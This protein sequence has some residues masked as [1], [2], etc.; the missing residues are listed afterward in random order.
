[1][2]AFTRLR[3]SNFSATEQRIADYILRNSANL[4]NLTIS[5]VAEACGTSKSMVVQLCK[6]AGFKG[7]KDLCSQLLIEHALSDQR[8]ESLYE[9]VHPGFSVA[10]ICQITV[11]Q[12]IRSIQ[13]TFEL[14]NPNVME[15]AVRM[16][17]EAD[18]IQLYGVGGSAVAALDLYNKLCRIGLNARFSQDIHCQLL[19]SASLTPRSVAIVISFN[20]MTNDMIDACALSKESGA[21]II[22]ITRFSH[23]A[24]RDMADLSLYVASNESL[25]RVTAMSSR[26]STL[27]MVDMLFACLASKKSDTIQPI[28]QRCTEIAQKR[29]KGGTRE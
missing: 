14:I 24:I 22:S 3:E 16:L 11:R 26:L 29:R 4:P 8:Y 28:V 12:E 13:D 2:S 20:G 23:N 1:M 15:E 5:T 7:Y 21:K 9:D 19:E 10:Q 6:T 27:C 18:R 25:R 17:M